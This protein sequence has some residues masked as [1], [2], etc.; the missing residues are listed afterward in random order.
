[1]QYNKIK[2]ISRLNSPT[3]KHVKDLQANIFTVYLVIL[4]SA[5]ILFLVTLQK[6]SSQE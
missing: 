2:D 4:R 3:L 1:M 5:S 6:E